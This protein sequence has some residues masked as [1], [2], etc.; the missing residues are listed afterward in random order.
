MSDK[1]KVSVS[2]VNSDGQ[3]F[4]VDEAI[5]QMDYN[6]QAKLKAL[7]MQASTGHRYEAKKRGVTLKK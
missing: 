3:K 5:A 6:Q 2:F 7:I 1:L 4:T